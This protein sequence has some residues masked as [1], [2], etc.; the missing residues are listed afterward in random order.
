M[1]KKVLTIPYESPIV[2]CYIQFYHLVEDGTLDGAI[3]FLNDIKLN[4]DG[5][6]ILMSLEDDYDDTYFALSEQ[7]LE[8]DEECQ[9]REVK[10]LQA[11]LKAKAKRLNKNISTIQKEKE[12]LEKLLK[13]YPENGYLRKE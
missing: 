7:R 3:T 12:L 1:K 13:K 8:T 11:S 4:A 10:E 5:K 6:K 9:E 2:G